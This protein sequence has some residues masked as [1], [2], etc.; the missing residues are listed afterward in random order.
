MSINIPRSAATM[1]LS[2]GRF[3][4]HPCAGDARPQCQRF[5]RRVPR[6]DDGGAPAIHPAP[7]TSRARQRCAPC[8]A[9]TPRDGVRPVRQHLVVTRRPRAP[10]KG[11]RVPERRLLRAHREDQAARPRRA[12]RR[13]RD[14]GRDP[15][16]SVQP[17][18]ARPQ[19]T[20]AGA[21][22]ESPL[23]RRH[24]RGD[25]CDAPCDRY[26]PRSDVG[27]RMRRSSASVTTSRTRPPRGLDD[28]AGARR[29]TRSRQ[30]APRPAARH[31]R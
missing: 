21:V 26:P 23:P 18:A 17:S 16:G 4:A 5:P 7:V 2:L 20:I 14:R 19:T 27:P 22:T 3:I 15:R 11:A 8:A 29:A 1:A 30:S 6:A 12:P 28:D 13:A 10:Q 9:G 25:V 24:L 31:P